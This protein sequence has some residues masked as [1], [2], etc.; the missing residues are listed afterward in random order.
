MPGEHCLTAE[1]G[2]CCLSELPPVAA[3]CA[4]SCRP[5]A[6]LYTRRCPLQAFNGSPSRGGGEITINPL[7]T[8]GRQQNADYYTHTDQ[9][10]AF[11]EVGR[12]WGGGG[13]L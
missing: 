3:A 9:T 5:E 1:A 4:C 11:Q 12:R 13:Q 2:A 6:C 10:R 7:D 8:D